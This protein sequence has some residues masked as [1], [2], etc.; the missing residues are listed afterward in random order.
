MTES[1]T[2]ST[3]LIGACRD[4]DM[5]AGIGEGEEQRLDTCRG[6]AGTGQSEFA[7]ALDAQEQVVALLVVLGH[8]IPAAIDLV[9]VGHLGGEAVQGLV[10][11]ELL[12]LTDGQCRE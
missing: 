4:E 7:G 10:V 12:E 9:V 8:A 1:G 11:G 6:F 5:T 3:D 2:R